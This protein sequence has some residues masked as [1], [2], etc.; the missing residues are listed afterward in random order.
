MSTHSRKLLQLGTSE[1]ELREVIFSGL[2]GVIDGFW[3][4]DEIR[5]IAIS[6]LALLRK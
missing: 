4:G 3:I 2:L 1:I 5:R 6:H